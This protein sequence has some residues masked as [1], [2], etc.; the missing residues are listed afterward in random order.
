MCAPWRVCLEVGNT[1]SP[2]PGPYP[3]CKKVIEGPDLEVS[4]CQTDPR[5][6]RRLAQA[7]QHRSHPAQ[8]G[9]FPLPRGT[10]WHT[11]QS[12]PRPPRAPQ[13]QPLW[14]LPSQHVPPGLGTC[15]D[16]P[17]PP[18]ALSPGG[19]TSLWPHTWGQGSGVGRGEPRTC[20][21]PPSWELREQEGRGALGRGGTSPRPRRLPGHC[22]LPHHWLC[23]PHP[24]ATASWGPHGHLGEGD[25]G[26][27]V[28][29][30][31][32]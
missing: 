6:G 23:L 25:K 4:E 26:V 29:S 22:L 27:I 18:S 16:P 20:Y 32:K 5:A 13:H 15:Q 7:T 9:A 12:T 24:D 1:A 21:C 2:E 17:L 3:C 10:H 31:D 28:V 30:L 19:R 8:E 14:P 11:C